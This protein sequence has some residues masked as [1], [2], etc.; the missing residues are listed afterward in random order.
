M[1]H[2]QKLQRHQLKRNRE[3]VDLD[4]CGAQIYLSMH[5]LLPKSIHVGLQ[6]SWGDPSTGRLTG[7]LLKRQ[8]FTDIFC[9]LPQW[10]PGIDWLNNIVIELR[11]YHDVSIAETTGFAYDAGSTDHQHRPVIDW[12]QFCCEQTFDVDQKLQLNLLLFETLQHIK[13]HLAKK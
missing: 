6:W 7:Y 5:R 1:Q 2:N 4:W 8:P 12:Q 11:L 9:L 10:V 3:S 13:S